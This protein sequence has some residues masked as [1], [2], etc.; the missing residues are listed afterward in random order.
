M[1]LWLVSFAW[2]RSFHSPGTHLSSCRAN[3]DIIPFPFRD[4]S[5]MPSYNSTSPSPYHT[6][7]ATPTPLTSQRPSILSL[8]ATFRPQHKPCPA[9]ARN[10]LFV[11]AY[12][13]LDAFRSEAVS[14]V[15]ERRGMQRSLGR[16]LLPMQLAGMS[17]SFEMIEGEFR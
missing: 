11:G 4:A 10:N 14:S 1:R 16:D 3:P 13:S 12:R 2:S 5:P 6:T 9:K 15:W 8:V 7:F 17:S